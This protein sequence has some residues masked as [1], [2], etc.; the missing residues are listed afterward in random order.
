MGEVEGMGAA[1]RGI[2]AAWGLHGDVGKM[3]AAIRRITVQII[4]VL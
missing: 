1:I 2:T 3:G 4:P